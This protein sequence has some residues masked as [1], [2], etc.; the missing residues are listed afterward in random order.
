[1]S[2]LDLPSWLI[3]A[4]FFVV[5]CVSRGTIFDMRPSVEKYLPNYDFYHNLSRM[6]QCLHHVSSQYSEFL[7]VQ[8]RY[9][10]R[11]GLTQ[12]VLRVSNFSLDSV[13]ENKSDNRSRIFF[14]YGEHAAEFFPVQSMFHLIENITQGYDLPQETYGGKF[15]RYLLN[16]FDLYI[17]TIVN[18][19]GRTIVEKT[20]N[21]CHMG[22]AKNADLNSDLAANLRRTSR[23]TDRVIAAEPECRV[24]RELMSRHS[25]DAFF[26]FHSGSRQILYPLSEKN[27]KGSDVDVFYLASL[28]SSSLKSSFT[29]VPVNTSLFDAGIFTYANQEK[30]ISLTY[31][32]SLWGEKDAKSDFPD[33][34]CF[35]T[36]NP[37]SEDLEAELKLIHPLYPTIF[38]FI[39]NW[40]KTQIL[41]MARQQASDKSSKTRGVPFS[42]SFFIFLLGGTC[43]LLL[44]NVRVPFS[45]KIYYRRQRRIVSLRSLGTLF[46]VICPLT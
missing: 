32:I 41:I 26:S 6:N 12:Y 46:A 44:C 35:S 1:M 3:V 11:M 21:Y 33:K 24:F 14:S 43:V 36:F 9:R 16:N 34:N 40:K 42:V 13:T 28:M 27:S 8:M 5:T 18:P 45:W 2:L 15:T 17:L 39:Q 4:A 30:Q 7:D 23:G 22:T 19:D 20:R 25:F 38:N 37:P 10:S 29:L 31:K